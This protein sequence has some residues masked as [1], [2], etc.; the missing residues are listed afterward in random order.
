MS[1]D[2]DGGAGR[3]ARV[4]GRLRDV[5]DFP[6]PGIVFKDIAPLLADPDA[7]GAAI[8]ALAEFARAA[9]GA[10]LVAGIEARGFLVAAALARELDCGIL[11]VRKAGKQ[12]PPTVRRAYDLENGR[13][14]YLVDDVLATGGT[15]RAAAEL[16]GQAG[17]EVIGI[18]V[19]LELGFLGGRARLDGVTHGGIVALLRT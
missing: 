16:I 9:G 6:Q 12:P 10:D 7:F 8:S 3:A 1:A 13:R 14:V 18:G 11:P 19:L 17:G 4:A 15:V 5:P 2:G